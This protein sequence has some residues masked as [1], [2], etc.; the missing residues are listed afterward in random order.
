M[1]R[2]FSQAKEMA[3]ESYDKFPEGMVEAV[4]HKVSQHEIKAPVTRDLVTGD[5]DLNCG[6]FEIDIRTINAPRGNDNKSPL[7]DNDFLSMADLRETQLF[8]RN[9]SILGIAPESL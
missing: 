5:Y 1:E 2:F 3:P 4:Y 9:N 8:D 6:Q 7:S